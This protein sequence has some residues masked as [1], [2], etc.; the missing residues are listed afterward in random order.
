MTIG[1]HLQE[2]LLATRQTVTLSTVTFQRN[3][4]RQR[5]SSI[6]GSFSRRRISIRAT[7]LF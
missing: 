5:R 1:I 3:Q 2:I 6:K 4:P 7:P